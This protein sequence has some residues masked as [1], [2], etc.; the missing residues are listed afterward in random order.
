M[1]YYNK[2]FKRINF[3]ITEAGKTVYF[4]RV[5]FT[6]FRI[7]CISSVMGFNSNITF[8][9]SVLSLTDVTYTVT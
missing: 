6:D 7:M 3:N 9:I 1:S 4:T 2:L 5:S 8:L